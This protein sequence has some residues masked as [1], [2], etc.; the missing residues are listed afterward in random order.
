VS[1][2]LATHTGG[3]QVKFSMTFLTDDAP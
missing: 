1:H 3:K 2:T